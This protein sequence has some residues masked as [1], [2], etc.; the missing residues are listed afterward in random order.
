[1]FRDLN[2]DGY[3]D[4]YVCNDFDTPDRI[5]IND[6]NGSFQALPVDAIRQTS[7]FA[8]GIDMADVDRDGDDD[9]L[10]LDMLARSHAI[11]M[12]QSGDVKPVMEFLTKSFPVHP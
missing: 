12:N 1:M 3:P 6:G 4:L 11:R 5:W 10:V 8:M 7:W 2:Q 9:I